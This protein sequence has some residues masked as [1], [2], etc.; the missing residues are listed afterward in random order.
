MPT[1]DNPYVDEHHQRIHEFASDYLDEDERDDF[2]DGLM[3]RRGYQRQH[4]WVAPEED[5]GQGSGGRK[6]VLK[7]RPAP[8][9][10][11]RRSGSYFKH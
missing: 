10:P 6:P 7:S 2:V 1:D 4:H 5:E 9:Q 3:E 8:Q 11:A